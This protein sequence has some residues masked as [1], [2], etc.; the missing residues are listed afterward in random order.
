MKKKT[1]FSFIC[2]Y[3]LQFLRLTREIL[4]GYLKLIFASAAFFAEF[5]A[6][7]NLVI[8]SFIC[9]NILPLGVYCILGTG[10]RYL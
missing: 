1:I 10:K 9:S 5:C 4:Y 3:I 6:Y 8:N 2:L 7:W